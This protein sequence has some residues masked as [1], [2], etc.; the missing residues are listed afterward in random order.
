[1]RLLLVF[2]FFPFPPNDGGR[3]GFFNPIKYLS[4]QHVVAVACL[5]GPQE[6]VAIEELKHYCSDVYIFKRPGG[7]VYRL[8][9]GLF[10]D[11]PGAAAKYWDPQAGEFIRRAIASHKPDIVE[12]HHLNMAAYQHF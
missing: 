3:I 6:D 11:P 12:F 10:S 1:M 5:V 2:P 8:A 7:D 4:R 9:K